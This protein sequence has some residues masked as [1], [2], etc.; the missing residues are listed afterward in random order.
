[1]LQ[2]VVYISEL[3]FEAAIV[4]LCKAEN[5]G[6]TAWL[7]AESRRPRRLLL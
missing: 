2:Q 3:L 6:T 4:Q 7:L 5:S 1:M